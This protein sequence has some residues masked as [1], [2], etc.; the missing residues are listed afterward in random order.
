MEP[1]RVGWWEWVG[2]PGSSRQAL[3]AKCD[4]GAATSAV[5]AEGLELS[6]HGE[7]TLARFKVM[8]DDPVVE[9]QVM[10]SRA[11]RSSNGE[12]EV[13][14]VVLVPVQL[15]GVT[16][17][18]EATL[19]NRISMQYPMLLGRSALAG[20]FVVDPSQGKLHPKPRVRR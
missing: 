8:P 17:A 5:H 15:A 3:R 2:L 6:S 4:T 13:R 16:F 7:I 20:R 12:H 1:V 14:P 10:N 18:I 9:L 19:T 11:V